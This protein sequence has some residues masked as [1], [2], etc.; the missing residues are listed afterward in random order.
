MYQILIVDSDEHHIKTIK[1][2]LEVVPEEYVFSFAGNPEDAL[3]I[4]EENEI[5]I[6]ICELE[7]P[8]MSGEELFYM[9][10]RISP[11]TIQ[12]ALS[13]AEDIKKT[14]ASINRSNAFR[15][16]LK[17]C[18]VS[19]DIMGPV[20]EA[21]KMQ[22]ARESRERKQE[23][24][25]KIAEQIH[26]E[27]EELSQILEEK[28]AEYSI[29]MDMVT[30]FVNNNLWMGGRIQAGS[31]TSEIQ[32]Y[33]RQVYE[34]FTRFYIFEAKDW[35]RHE[36]NLRE[37]FYDAKKGHVFQIQ[38]QVEGK[39]P[40]GMLPNICY[41]LYLL[42]NLV[43]TQL[44]VYQAQAVLSGDENGVRLSF[45]CDLDA[46]RDE[47]GK[48]L[49]RITNKENNENIYRETLHVLSW[50]SSQVQVAREK[51]PYAVQV[52]FDNYSAKAE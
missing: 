12:I 15:L 13:P 19:S 26:Q 39:I 32:D 1:K 17:P 50:I 30:G 25:E 29:V 52:N 41:A 16:I 22:A 35:N 9:T 34:A 10:R 46:S 31:I 37:E 47:N 14:L 5:D 43:R 28:K 3:K 40:S 2:I 38:N 18:K 42:L 48:L 23:E 27:N 6:L 24:K 45:A 49:I 11:R 21:L 33:I 7:L 8:V 4:I 51:N 20:Q 36:R 44:L